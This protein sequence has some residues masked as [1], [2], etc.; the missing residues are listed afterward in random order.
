MPLFCYLLAPKQ[1]E[2]PFVE[3]DGDLSSVSDAG[4]LDSIDS[5]DDGPKDEEI[6]FGEPSLKGIGEHRSMHDAM[7]ELRDHF[8]DAY[9]EEE[10]E[11][12]S[13]FVRNCVM[14]LPRIHVLR[15]GLNTYVLSGW[16]RGAL[17]LNF[18]N[19]LLTMGYACM[20]FCKLGAVHVPPNLSC[21]VPL[22]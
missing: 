18:A 15:L 9:D 11:G 21:T 3:D 19:C 17:L 6:L 10:E 7:A 12:E 2:K 13:K 1:K 14:F 5:D 22:C 4:S 16:R 20:T 8:G